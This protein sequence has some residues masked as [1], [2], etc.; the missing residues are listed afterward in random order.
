[1]YTVQGLRAFVEVCQRGTVTAA[2]KAI[3]R[4]QPQVS[5]L[6][7][8]LEAELG[9]ALF[10]REGRRLAPTPRGV[11]FFEEA[12]RA[13]AAFDDIERVVSEL[14]AEKD[15]PIR[16]LAPPHA[17]HTII[18]PAIA[19]VRK[20]HPEFHVQIEIMTRSTIGTW[21]NYRPFDIGIAALPFDL[22]WI[23]KQPFARTK[24]LMLV[25]KAH[26]LAS[27]QRVSVADTQKYPLVALQPSSYA[28]QQMDKEFKRLGIA[29]DIVCET[30][31][32]MSACQLVAS[33]IG[34]TPVDPLL[35]T[36]IGLTGVKAVEWDIPIYLEYCFFRPISGAS[37]PLIQKFSAALEAVVTEICDGSTGRFIKRLPAVS[38]KHDPRKRS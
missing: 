38:A 6:I 9:F 27:M 14:R 36:A 29:P 19:L 21:S 34:I 35:L 31:N 4:T 7:S 12:H 17:V 5:R 24:M 25:P 11:R 15:A 18:P 16:V 28:R 1:M 2:A 8:E 13:L 23:L 32:V 10:V 37:S 26:P 3:Y 30:Q 20:K 22:P 33:G